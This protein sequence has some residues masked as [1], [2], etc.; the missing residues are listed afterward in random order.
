MGSNQPLPKRGGVVWRNA[1]SLA[2]ENTSINANRW[3]SHWETPCQQGIDDV[4]PLILIP[5]RQREKWG[6]H[7][8]EGGSWPGSPLASLLHPRSLLYY[9]LDLRLDSMPMVCRN[10]MGKWSSAFSMPKYTE[11][12]CTSPKGKLFVRENHHT[13]CYY[14]QQWDDPF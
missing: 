8:L 4:F 10:E 7:P 2:Q 14:I 6:H 13:L 12:V 11:V 3:S 5:L 9:I 1:F